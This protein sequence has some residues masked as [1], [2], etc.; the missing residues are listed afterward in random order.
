MRVTTQPASNTCLLGIQIP[1]L[2]PR[3]VLRQAHRLETQ[4]DGMLHN[5][6]E[7]VHSVARAELARVGMHGEGHGGGG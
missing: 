3:H 7:L 4:L 1:L 2:I 6:L 5:V